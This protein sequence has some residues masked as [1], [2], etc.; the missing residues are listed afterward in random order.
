MKKILILILPCISFFS[1][2]CQSFEKFGQ[3]Y[4]NFESLLEQNDS[5]D[6]KSICNQFNI[7][8]SEINYIPTQN[9]IRLSSLI[10]ERGDS[11]VAKK[12]LIQAIKNGLDDKKHIGQKLNFDFEELF[13]KHGIQYN[14]SYKKAIDSMIIWDQC[15]R[16]QKCNRRITEVDSSNMM[17]MLELIKEFGFPSEKK[18]GSIS[19]NAAIVMILHFDQDKTHEI[20]GPILKEAFSN[21]YI[22]PRYYAWIKDRRLAWGLDKEQYYHFIPT[23]AFKNYDK[24]KMDEI[25]KRRDSIGLKIKHKW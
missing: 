11:L 12:F 3:F 4:Y 6:V 9:L 7:I 15:C 1:V 20:W 16:T 13:D 18:V 8:S 23:P 2:Q 21:G 10:Y 17:F 25:Q 14:I 22:S 5:L 24:R 19:A